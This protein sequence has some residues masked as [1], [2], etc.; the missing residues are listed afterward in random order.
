MCGPPPRLPGCCQDAG[1]FKRGSWP[2]FRGPQASG[3]A[4]GQKLPDRWNARTGEK[5][6]GGHP[7][8]AWRIRVRS[9]GVTASSSR[10]AISTDRKATLPAGP[11]RRRR[12]VGGSLAPQVDD[13]CDRQAQRQDRLGARGARGTAAS[14]SGTSSPHMPARRPPPTAAS[15]SHG[16]DRRASTPTTSHGHFLWKVDLG[17]VDI[18]AYDIPTFEWGPASSPII[19]N[20]LVIVQ[21]DTQADSFLIALDADTGETVWKTERDELPS[22]GTPTVAS[23][24]RGTGA[25]DQ[26]LQLHPGLRPA[27][28]KGAVAARRQLEDHRADADLRPTAC[29]S[30]R[31][32]A[33]PERRFSPCGRA[34]AATVTACGPAR[35]APRRRLEPQ[36]PRAVHADAARSTTA[37]STSLANNGVFD[38]Y[39]LQTGEE[40][41]RQRLPQIGSGFSASPVAADGKIYLSN[42]DGDMLVVAAGQEFK[43]IATNSMGEL[44]MATPALSDG[45]MYVRTSRSLIAIG[46]KR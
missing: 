17:R 45:V 37:C 6:S 31:A 35:A 36:R 22:W 12:R 21:C 23:T 14:T 18:G 26:R 41:Y 28:R 10:A 8:P 5:S 4:D 16:S 1:D 42:E 24:P 32:A 38:A 13:L 25:R 43:H 15:S 46:R 11:L 33:R 27:H 39:D 30:S 44:L 34:R 2:S 3:V 7:F 40:I 9:S 20:G 19:W 29:S